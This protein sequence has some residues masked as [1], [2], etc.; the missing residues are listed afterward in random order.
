MLKAANAGYAALVLAA[1]TLASAPSRAQ[2]AAFDSDTISGLGARNIGSATMSGRISALTAVKENGRLTVYIGSASGGVWK[3]V[4][5]GTTFKPIFDKQPVQSIGAVAVDPQAPKNIWVGTGESWTRNSV[6]I[7]DGIYRSTDGGENWTHLGLTESERVS[8]ILIDPKDGNTVYVCVPGKLWS[9]SSDRG[10]YKTTD[11]GKTWSKILKGANPSTGCSMMSMDPKDS[12]VLY[13]GMWDFRRKGWTFRSGGDTPTSPSGSAFYKSSDGGATW[14]ELDDKSAPGLPPKPWGRIAVTVAPSNSNVVYVLIESTRSALFRSSDAGKSWQERDRSNQMVWRPFYFAN[15]IVDPKNENRLYKPDLTLVVSD[16]GGKSFSGAGNGAHGD[17]HDLW[18]NP[19]NTDQLISGDDGGVWYS[20]DRANTW[21]K[22]NNLPVA[23]FYHVSA[24]MADPYQVYGGLQDNSSWVGDSQYP[25]GITNS[26]WENLFGGDGFW[27]FSDPGDP[28][29]AYAEAQGGE[30]GRINR[31][32]LEKRQ[33]KPQPN[34]GEPKLRFNWNTPIHMSPN[35]KGTIYIGAQYLFRSHDH[36]QTW[37]RISPDLTT[38]DPEKQKQEESG[39]VTVDNSSAET[40]ETIY[41][42]SESPRD[43]KTIWV[44]TDDGNLQLTRDGGKTWTNV[45][46][47][48]P[49]LPKFSWVSWVEASVHDAATAYAVFDRH[50]FGDMNPYVFKTTD[51]GKTWT[52]I[53]AADSGVRG[54]AHVVK[55]DTVSPNLL[56][57]GTELGLWI[58]PNGGKQWAQYKGHEFPCVAVRDLV[59]QP[60][61]SDLVIATHGRG[62]WVIDD[63][64][65]LRHLTP[66]VMNEEAGFLP[67][68]PVQQRID[69]SGGWSEGSAAFEGPNPPFGAWITYYQKK[70]HIFGRMKLEVFNS[71]GKLIDTL[72]TNSRGGISRVSWSMHLKAPRVPPAATAAFEAAQ[73]PRVVPG[74]YTVKMTRGKE[75]YTETL[76]IGLD[77]RAKYTVE[78]RKANFDAAMRVYNLLGDMSYDV[79]RIN[80]VRAALSDRVAKLDKDPALAKQLQELSSKVE[81]IRKKIVATKEG[82]AITG[83]ERLR[84][85]TAE[86]YGTLNDY[87]GRPG[88]YQVARIESLKKELGDVEAE[89]DALLAKELPG[90]NKS[91]A[92]K[93]LPPI[94]PIARK[95][96]DAANSGDS[97]SSPKPSDAIFWARD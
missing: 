30:V 29:F 73:G 68:R 34:Y 3:S 84:E 83:E 80:G 36:G 25:G 12:K 10:V 15:L 1:L 69:A 57:V 65:P 42:I 37:D 56:F 63:I 95:D 86:L 58:S 52:P 71:D 18:I 40:H 89:F 55:E 5:G 54:Y 70:R 17:F 43:G 2:Q 79:D 92:Q 90:V 82:G 24:D 45:V 23:Q 67:G 72:P 19:E 66:E 81:D 44:G 88:D 39:G 74:T 51:Y 8:K 77:A 60:R 47:N 46:G 20:Y 14:N 41:S 62:I 61:D 97:A 28:N 6:S 11:A 32:T 78:D 49:N 7:G 9:D 50:T 13:A 31:S 26:R 21:W 35:E 16:D 64:T 59:V 48:V 27:A 91:L 96:W 93:K 38:N 22:A 53:I 75:T 87:E 33:I 4:N 76:T 85:K 94:Q